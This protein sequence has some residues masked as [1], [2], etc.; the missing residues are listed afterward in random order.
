M[1][2]SSRRILVVTG[3]ILGTVLLAFSAIA[4]AHDLRGTTTGAAAGSRHISAA[5]AL[6]APAGSGGGQPSI[7]GNAPG[8]KVVTRT[9]SMSALAAGGAAAA[10]SPGQI[11]AGAQP[12]AGATSAAPV[13]GAVQNGSGSGYAGRP[14]GSPAAGNR[15]AAGGAVAGGAAANGTASGATPAGNP[16][17]GATTA[18]GAANGA[19]AGGATTGGATN[20]SGGTS[21]IVEGSS[22]AVDTG[23]TTVT[24]HT[25]VS[26]VNGTSVHISF[27]GDGTLDVFLLPVAQ[28]GPSPSDKPVVHCAAA[29]EA[30]YDF[31]DSS[32]AF[33][34]DIVATASGT[35][36]ITKL[37]K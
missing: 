16:A 9:L 19:I 2:A 13:A 8:G 29:C 34:L 31:T 15:A 33:Y 18:N 27:T 1:S 7:V 5:G 6:A 17:A 24:Q 14:A 36:E 25:Q 32:G 37:T 12:A 23:G 28:T 26:V 3:S 11:A 20:S 22:T 35:T 10:T 4:I 21:T 30:D